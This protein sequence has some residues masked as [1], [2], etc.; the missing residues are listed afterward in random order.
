MPYKSETVNN[1]T[2]CDNLLMQSDKKSEALI[3]RLI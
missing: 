1:S 2:Y 3:Y